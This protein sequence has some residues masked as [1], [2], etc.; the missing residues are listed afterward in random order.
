MKR[1][2]GRSAANHKHPR[3]RKPERGSPARPVITVFGSAQARRGGRLYAESQRMG[4]LL[5]Q[6]GF[7]LM[8][9]GYDGVMEA[10]SRGGAEAGAH[11]TGVTL[12]RFGS[13]VNAH[14]VDE[15]RTTNFYERFTWLIDRADGYVA[16]HGGIGTLAEVVFA[17]QEL[18]VGTPG[19]RPLILVGERWRRLLRVFRDNLIA[20]AKIYGALTVVAT[21]EAAIKLLAAHF[22]GAGIELSARERRP[23]TGSRSAEAG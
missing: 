3:P 19:A 5:G 23:R 14:V 10:I 7:D 12:D 2:N 15:I 21:P 22:A 20:P 9:G 1:E 17:W 11:V 13:V 8:T 6:A 16:M 18:V 4:E